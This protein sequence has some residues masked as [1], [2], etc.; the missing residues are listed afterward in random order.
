M[1]QRLELVIK[2]QVLCLQEYLSLLTLKIINNFGKTATY[3]KMKICKAFFNIF[4]SNMALA[5][6]ATRKQREKRELELR[7]MQEE[8]STG[9]TW[10]CR[11]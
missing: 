6:M 4:F 7:Q 8:A 11:H 5:G 2:Y 1:L 9:V 3:V 10:L